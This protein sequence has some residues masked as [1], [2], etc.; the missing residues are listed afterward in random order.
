MLPS[1]SSV[2][3][4]LNEKSHHNHFKSFSLFLWFHPLFVAVHNGMGCAASTG[5]SH[6]SG[7]N[8]AVEAR[9]AGHQ[10]QSAAGDVPTAAVPHLSRMS[11][12]STVTLPTAVKDAT[13]ANSGFSNQPVSTPK[14]KRRSMPAFALPVDPQ[15][16]EVQ[17]KEICRHQFVLSEAQSA[18]S[19]FAWDYIP[20]YSSPTVGRQVGSNSS[21]SLRGSLSSS[22]RL[23]VSCGAGGIVEADENELSSVHNTPL[24][25]STN[26]K[27]EPIAPMKLPILPIRQGMLD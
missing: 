19:P 3:F 16:A 5:T 21:P 22:G 6:P 25:P 12:E 2:R 15:L 11:E 10:E 27:S 17:H 20:K 24:S 13:A 1:L 18:L 26:S 9:A 23:D 8:A 4:F 7:V 14:P